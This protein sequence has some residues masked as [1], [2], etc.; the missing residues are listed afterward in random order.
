MPPSIVSSEPALCVEAMLGLVADAQEVLTTHGVAGKDALIVGL[1]VGSYAATYL[2]S[3]IG[4]RVC[5]VASADRGDLVIWES[6]ATRIV[7]HRAMLKDHG[8]A[9][10]SVALSG[11]HPAENLRG[12]APN[13]L[14]VVRTPRPLHPGSAGQRLA[15]GHSHACAT[16]PRC[17]NPR[18]PFRCEQPPSTRVGRSHGTPT[19]IEAHRSEAPILRAA[20]HR[21]R[22][23][24][25]A[26]SPTLAEGNSLPA[27]TL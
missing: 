15:A 21:P 5:V 26:G 7:K 17:Q 10:Y 9:D 1:S 14:L 22:L 19:C 11:T 8:I 13:S 23:P 12:L 3:Q 25:S 27:L 6:F 24:E 4:S 2:G 18:W 16:R 20:A